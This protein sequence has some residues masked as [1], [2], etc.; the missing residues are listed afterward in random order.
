MVLIQATSRAAVQGRVLLVLVSAALLAATLLEWSPFNQQT[1]AA[2][3]SDSVPAA[4][5]D[6][7]PG[8]EDGF[9]RSLN[10]TGG[11]VF[12]FDCSKP[13]NVQNKLCL[14]NKGEPCP[15]EASSSC[16]NQ[17]CMPLGC[18]MRQGCMQVNGCVSN[19]VYVIPSDQYYDWHANY[20]TGSLT[21]SALHILLFAHI[22]SSFAYRPTY[23]HTT[24]ITTYHAP[25]TSYYHSAAYTSHYSAPTVVNG[26]VAHTPM[27]TAVRPGTPV[28]QARPIG[29]SYGGAAVSGA[30]VSGAA[31][32]GAAVGTAAGG[33]GGYGGAAGAQ[34]VAQGRPVTPSSY[35][36]APVV[37]GRPVTSTGGYPVVQGRPVGASS[38][39]SYS[40]R[41]AYSSSSYSSR[42]SWST[43]SSA[44]RSSA[45]FRSSSSYSCFSPDALVSR[46][47]G[48]WAPISALHAGELVAGWPSA[49][50]ALRG[51]P[52]QPLRIAAVRHSR[53]TDESD[54]SPL[55][56]LLGARLLLPGGRTLHL[57][58]FVTPNHALLDAEG[59]WRAV[60]AEAAQAEMDEYLSTISAI[61]AI[62]ARAVLGDGRAKAASQAAADAADSLR[63]AKPVATLGVGAKLLFASQNA[64]RAVATHA[65]LEALI[66][67][68]TAVPTQH[69]VNL[70]LDVVGLA[71]YVVNGLLVVD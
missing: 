69:V 29:G 65:T 17:G 6:D 71:V 39:S 35:G 68:P 10:A 59:L 11:E 23:F 36:S 26:H 19:Q 4:A 25:V 42:S 41:P 16:A 31:V 48:S 70:E 46:A 60:N 34:Q 66:E 32:S 8:K 40:S 28:A 53:H 62:S 7:F 12:T 50:A 15:A 30:A 3:D 38:Y 43:V 20:Y 47:N 63:L 54:E 55:P 44:S 22:Y 49:A 56:P 37:Q 33:Y 14:I 18:D 45:A 1:F 13:E 2:D 52:S 9:E 61:S 5:A 67:V 58:P 64:S 51:E 27:A 24:V 57:P 21:A